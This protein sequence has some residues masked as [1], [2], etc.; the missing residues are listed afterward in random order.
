MGST[1]IGRIMQGL[2][3]PKCHKP[4]IW[5]STYNEWQYYCTEHGRFNRLGQIQDPHT[6]EAELDQHFPAKETVERSNR[7]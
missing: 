3:C 1:P 6:L 5:F 4:S 2:N 7:S